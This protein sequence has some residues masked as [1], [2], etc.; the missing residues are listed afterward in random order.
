MTAPAASPAGAATGGPQQRAELLKLIGAVAEV[1]RG[2]GRAD[3]VS[4]LSAAAGRLTSEGARV[5]VVGEF[6]KGKSS[7]VNALVGG[8]VCPV[9]DDISTAV[10][11]VLRYADALA[12]TGI[13]VSG[14][15]PKETA[16]PLSASQLRAA[17]H[18]GSD[19]QRVEVAVPSPLL[20]AGLT[21]ID[22]PG[23]GGLQ[24]EHALRTLATLPS[25][26]ALV[27]VSD[28]MSELTEPEVSFLGHAMR[29]CGTVICVMAKTDIFPF[30]DAVV[31]AN[32]AHLERAGI[33]APILTVSCE[34]R[35]RGRA[36][37]DPA[38][39]EASGFGRLEGVL[40]QRIAPN[41]EALA[42]RSAG[43]DVVGVL[44]LLAA[45]LAAAKQALATGGNHEDLQ[46]GLD[47]AKRRAEALR[48]QTSKW[49]LVL[50]DGMA[51]LQGEVDHDMRTRMRVI[52]QEAES[53]IDQSDPVKMWD[54]FAQWLE[55]RVVY[56][57]TENYLLLTRHAH[58]L[59]ERVAAIF[60]EDAADLGEVINVA[61][62]THLLDGVIDPELPKAALQGGAGATAISLFRNT[63]SGM[64]MFGALGGASMLHLFT[65][66]LNPITLGLGLVLGTRSVSEEHNRQVETRRNHAKSAV[67]RYTDE[68]SFVVGKDS[69]DAVRSLQRALRDTYSARAE[70]LVRSTTAAVQEATAALAGAQKDRT[71][72]L[73]DVDKRLS[74]L[75]QLAQQAARF[76]PSPRKA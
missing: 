15:P 57:V 61:A 18:D 26:H 44:Q 1:A 50:N 70:E 24:S 9:D 47:D 74:A 38:L 13:S 48:G 17:I 56:D 5:A 40:V 21:L 2:A 37:N 59:T 69:R 12:I 72:K 58:D 35:A 14:D 53:A 75:A 45:P 33:A 16:H 31:A 64:S 42:L 30:V 54:E 28:A 62:P 20:K 23:V 60:A 11:T 29:L 51:D 32:R 65:G 34:L 22:T 19:Y 55:T 10:P 46:A 25:V 76:A 71:A 39:G 6:K 66:S 52:S 73:A 49:Q 8:P 43:T 27:F 41:A 68:A 7:V 36:A 3:L 63:Y 4:R 67:R